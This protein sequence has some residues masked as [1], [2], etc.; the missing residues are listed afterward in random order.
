MSRTTLPY[1]LHSEQ[2]H[3]LNTVSVTLKH[4]WET[5]V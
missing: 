1:I 5:E 4:I 2:K 3:E